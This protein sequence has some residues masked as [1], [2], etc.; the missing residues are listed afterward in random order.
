MSSA[1]KDERNSP[2]NPIKTMNFN[3]N[4]GQGEFTCIHTLNDKDG[5]WWKSDFGAPLTITKI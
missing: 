2:C 1:F 5:P 4:W 3:A